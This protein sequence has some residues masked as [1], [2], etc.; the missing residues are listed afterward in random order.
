MKRTNHFLTLILF[1]F[2][3]LLSFLISCEDHRDENALTAMEEV[4]IESNA[5]SAEM[6]VDEELQDIDEALIISDPEGGRSAVECAEVTRDAIAKII[7]IDFGDGCIGPGGNVRS[8]KIRITYGANFDDGLANRVITFENYYVN[9]KKITGSIELRD[10]NLNDAGQLNATRRLNQFT[11]HFPEGKT[12][13]LT[14]TTTLTWIEGQGDDDRGND[15]IRIT[16]SYAGVNY[17][18]RDISY[19][20]LEPVIADFSCRASGGF[21][22]TAGV[23][24]MK[25]GQRTRIVSYGDGSCDQLI[26]IT[27]N[28]KVY[29]IVLS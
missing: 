17:Q 6:V 15:V 21:L 14:G 4:E 8:G 11:V 18:G 13:T 7:T 9:N 29:N 2:A 28:G 22:R 5:T 25:I 1:S 24:E 12:F 27:I 20:I 26:T 19:S 3:L 16:G 23:K 10:F